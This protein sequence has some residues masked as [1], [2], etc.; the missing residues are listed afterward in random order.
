[1]SPAAINT[2]ARI[3]IIGVALLYPYALPADFVGVVFL[4]ARPG[5]VE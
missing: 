1:L 3:V 4:S 5:R 2:S